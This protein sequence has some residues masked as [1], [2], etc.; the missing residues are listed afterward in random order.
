MKQGEVVIAYLHTPKERVWGKIIELSE[1]GLILRGL[2]IN[3]FE[4]WCRQVAKGETG[5]GLST[6]MYPTYRIE[7][8]LLDEEIGGI[9]SFSDK[10]YEL[11]NMTIDNYFAE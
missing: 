2:D 3:S 11:T 9:P 1:I 10:F 6:V 5:I 7:K 8:I 4:D